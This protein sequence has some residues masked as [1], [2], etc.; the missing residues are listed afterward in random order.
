[1]I[2][3][4]FPNNN[5]KEFI[6]TAKKLGYSGLCF[7]YSEKDK[8]NLARAEKL[9]SPSFK[10]F[11]GL[12]CKKLPKAKADLYLVEN[13]D[14]FFLK[15]NHDL[16]FNIEGPYD[17]IHQRDSGLNHIL[18]KMMHKNNTAYGISFSA[19]LNTANRHVLL[20]QIMQNVRLCQK[21]K[22]GIALLSFA[23]EPFEMRSPNDLEAFGRVLGMKDAK[24]SLN[25]AENMLKTK[26][27]QIAKGIE[28]I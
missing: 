22:V 2:D 26:Q 11:T 27:K 19:I 5:E 7:V 6:L 9:K 10:I 18:C 8:N 20:G 16:I 3:L 28:R 12:V 14:R 15:G 23:K 17:F 24:K 21:Y 4:V 25:F 1:M 13:N